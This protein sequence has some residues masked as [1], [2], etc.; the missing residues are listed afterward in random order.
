MIE[1]TFPPLSERVDA[2]DPDEMALTLAEDLEAFDGDHWRNQ[3]STQRKGA[4]QAFLSS[5]LRT[6]LR[7]LGRRS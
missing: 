5:E 6:L 1:R 4:V 3:P 2:L 7:Y